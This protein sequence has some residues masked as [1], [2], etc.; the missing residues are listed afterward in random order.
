M[1]GILGRFLFKG[2]DVFLKIRDILGGEKAR[3]SLLKMMLSGANTLILDEPT[4]H[5]DIESKEVFEEALREF[6]GTAII[7]THDRYF[8][9]KIPNRILELTQDGM[10]EY[11]G[12]YDFYLEK[13]N[14]IKSA[15]FQVD[16]KKYLLS[17]TSTMS[18]SLLPVRAL[19]TTETIAPILDAA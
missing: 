6:P 10:V 16:T 3:L 11:L 1:R 19:F 13:K 8:L 4:N 12:K 7:V 2:D 17:D 9:K 15:I 5:M 14:S 18:L